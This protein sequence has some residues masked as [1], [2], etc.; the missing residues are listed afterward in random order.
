M[1]A[2]LWIEFTPSD[3]IV[4]AILAVIG[5]EGFALRSLRRL[6]AFGSPRETL[7]I[8]LGGCRFN[9]DLLLL[10]QQLRRLDDDLDIIHRCAQRRA[11]DAGSRPRHIAID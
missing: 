7:M 1:T 6:P 5:G 8:E 10:E 3:T 9:D 4:P 2:T 11:F